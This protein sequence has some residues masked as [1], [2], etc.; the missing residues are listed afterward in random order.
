[1]EAED[2][3]VCFVTK[4]MLEELAVAP[5]TSWTYATQI[6]V[7]LYAMTPGGSIVLIET[8][9]TKPPKKLIEVVGRM[10]YAKRYNKG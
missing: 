4:T 6:R 8:Y 1:M 2:E 3:V 9:S 7:E 5:K 10:I